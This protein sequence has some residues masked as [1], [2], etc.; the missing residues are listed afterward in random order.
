METGTLQ[1]TAVETAVA[2]PSDIFQ[3]AEDL[4]KTLGLTRNE[5]Y[6]EALEEW[7]KHKR[8]AENHRQWKKFY[9]EVDSSLDPVLMQMQMMSLEPE[10][11]RDAL[12]EKENGQA[13]DIHSTPHP[14]RKK[15][16]PAEKAEI[17][18]E[19]NEL[20]SRVDSSLDPFVMQLQMTA[21]DPEEW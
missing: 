7:M 8:D 19:L 11:E 17:T 20:Y 12:G 1:L 4:A 5:A 15:L 6:A 9:D 21:L 3:Q 2:I 10:S 13:V 16:S 14:R 18:L